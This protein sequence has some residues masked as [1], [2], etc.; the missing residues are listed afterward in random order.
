VGAKTFHPALRA[1]AVSVKG[2]CSRDDDFNGLAPNLENADTIVF[3]TPLYWFTFPAKIKI[4]I[5]KLY[6]F[7]MKNINTINIVNGYI[8]M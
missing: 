2:A 4:V 6:S 3:C 1:T 8:M 5:D 7:I